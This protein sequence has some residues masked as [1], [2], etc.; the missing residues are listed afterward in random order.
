MISLEHLDACDRRI[1]DHTGSRPLGHWDELLNAMSHCVYDQHA[2]RT[3]TVCV[4]RPVSCWAYPPKTE[5]ERQIIVGQ[6][7]IVYRPGQ[8]ICCFA[9]AEDQRTFAKF[10]FDLPEQ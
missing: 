4:R 6:V 9:S 10:M 8:N 3:W 2:G 1:W 5:M 7:R